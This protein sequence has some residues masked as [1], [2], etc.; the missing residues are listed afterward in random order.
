MTTNSGL[1]D[2][3][4]SIIK[5]LKATNKIQYLREEDDNEVSNLKK[6]I[7]SSRKILESKHI[8]YK[9]LRTIGR[10][11]SPFAGIKAPKKRVKIDK[12]THKNLTNSLMNKHLSQNSDLEYIMKYIQKRHLSREMFLLFN[13]NFVSLTPEINSII[14]HIAN[15]FLELFLGLLDVI[16]I[17]TSE[18][19]TMDENP[20]LYNGE[21]TQLGK[22]I[23][24]NPNLLY[25]FE[26]LEQ[27]LNLVLNLV[28]PYNPDEEYQKD[29]F[30]NVLEAI[31]S[32][33]IIPN[34]EL[35]NEELRKLSN[36]EYRE[37]KTDLPQNEI[38]IF[39]LIFEKISNS[40]DEISKI[41]SP[42][43]Q[44]ISFDNESRTKLQEL[45]RLLNNGE[46]IPIYILI[47]YYIKS[48]IEQYQ[49]QNIVRFMYLEYIIDMNIA[50]FNKHNHTKSGGGKRTKKRGRVFTTYKIRN[51][52]L[53]NKINNE[54]KLPYQTI[55]GISKGLNTKYVDEFIGLQTNNNNLMNVFYKK[56]KSTG[57]Y[58][59][60]HL[61]LL[62]GYTT[63]VVNDDNKKYFNDFV[64][65]HFIISSF[66]IFKQSAHDFSNLVSQ[67]LR[68]Y[69]YSLTSKSKLLHIKNYQEGM[70][71][72][73]GLFRILSLLTSLSYASFNDRLLST[74]F[75]PKIIQV[76]KIRRKIARKGILQMDNYT[77]NL[78]IV[79]KSKLLHNEI[80]K[81]IHYGIDSLLNILDRFLYSKHIKLFGHTFKE[82]I[83]AIEAAKIRN[84]LV[85]FLVYKNL[86]NLMDTI[87]KDNDNAENIYA[88]M[89]YSL[90]NINE[91][92]KKDFNT[93]KQL[94]FD[95]IACC[96]M[97]E[98]LFSFYDNFKLINLLSI[99][100]D[101]DK[102]TDILLFND[103]ELKLFSILFQNNYISNSD[104]SNNYFEMTLEKYHISYKNQFDKDKEPIKYRFINLINYCLNYS[105]VASL[106]LFEEILKYQINRDHLFICSETEEYLDFDLRQPKI[107]DRYG[108]NTTKDRDD[109]IFFL[110]V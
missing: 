110:K 53:F 29:S 98:K 50:I 1:V 10:I 14:K 90:S 3:G 24:N 63:L 84:I 61:R 79:G 70:L 54:S 40:F 23:K 89:G 80:Y 66:N 74:I 15:N 100:E 78:N 104:K 65:K 37:L 45:L 52:E 25:N 68:K 92:E 76:L 9:A 64:A 75:S 96:F 94:L 95:K 85:F 4:D 56:N 38:T 82:D 102:N 77:N 46:K 36:D 72:K 97:F 20:S 55:E 43:N 69:Y 33:L 41:L 19:H 35:I 13:M 87:M 34:Q 105:F 5:L 7:I 67:S 21:F 106:P 32:K 51:Q 107:N 39:K 108:R 81:S 60:N 99:L 47:S 44:K 27:I 16:M 28:C 101:R 30:P 6:I 12:L 57:N 83:N 26:T 2:T 18:L 22:K 71:S 58:E 93:T 73:Y 8:K 17:D 42:D 31:F 88:I 49:I 91:N 62:I 11:I 48:I 103:K 86:N 59:Y 109:S